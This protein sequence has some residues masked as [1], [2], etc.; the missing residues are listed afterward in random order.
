[1]FGGTRAPRP[2]SNPSSTA[3]T[4]RSTPISPPQTP[5]TR[6]TPKSTPTSPPPVTP[7]PRTSTLNSQTHDV[8]D[9]D[10]ETQP[11][12]SPLQAGTPVDLEDPSSQNTRDREHK[13]PLVLTV[14]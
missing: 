9:R 10:S 4:P 6:V 8:D 2:T 5:K 7:P 1:M 14:N 13:K 12:S 3:P 11:E